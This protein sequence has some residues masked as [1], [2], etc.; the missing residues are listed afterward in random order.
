ML[1]TTMNCI[2]ALCILLY[3][4]LCISV[5]AL[6]CS[7][8]ACCSQLYKFIL[9]YTLRYDS[10][11]FFLLLRFFFCLLKFVPVYLLLLLPFVCICSMS[12]PH[13]LESL[14][15]DVLNC[16]A[17]CFCT[18]VCLL[19]FVL[20]CIHCSALNELCEYCTFV[21]FESGAMRLKSDV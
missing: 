16:C 11:T 8:E 17:C 13:V 20:P 5:L 4:A 2:V 10:N 15:R 9:I 7:R 21:C 1:A 18:V 14:L 6:H 3:F 19:G 12:D